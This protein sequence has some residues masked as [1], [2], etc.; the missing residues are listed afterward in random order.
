[1]LKISLIGAFVQLGC[2]QSAFA[3]SV[4]GEYLFEIGGFGITNS[5]ATTWVFA[6]IIILLFCFTRDN[7]S[8]YPYI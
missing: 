5:M 7:I 8:R 4:K 2:A 3:A 1:M 6:I